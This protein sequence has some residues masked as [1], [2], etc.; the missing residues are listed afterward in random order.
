MRFSNSRKNDE[1]GFEPLARG[2][3]T[4]GHRPH[5]HKNPRKIHQLCAQVRQVIDLCLAER[6]DHPLLE[7]VSVVSVTPFPDASRLLILVSVEGDDP[8][9]VQRLL[10]TLRDLRPILRQE[11]SMEINR[12]RTP[13][14]VFDLI[15]DPPP[16]SFPPAPSE[17]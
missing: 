1:G 15:P 3:A 12:K 8:I 14:I 4:P 11:I 2:A 13:E 7:R 16:P 9:D 17:D 5:A 6:W 10:A